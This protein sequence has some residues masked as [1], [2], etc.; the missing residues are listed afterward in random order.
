MKMRIQG[1]AIRFR[2]NRKEV[3]ELAVRARSWN[4]LNSLLPVI[5]ALSMRS[6]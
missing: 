2:L 5:S 4:P 6:R 1:N 3:A